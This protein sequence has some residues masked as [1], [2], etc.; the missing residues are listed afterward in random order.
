MQFIDLKFQYSKIK[1]KVDAGIAG[2]L[3][4]GRYIMG[5][6]VVA[7]EE[8]LAGY[9]GTKH[10]LG[11]S[12]GT[13]ALLIALMAIGVKP[14]DEIITTPFTFIA[15]GEVIALAG[16]KP[17]YV[18]IKEDTYNI[19]VTKIEEKITSKTKAI[20]P[21]S[22]YGQCADYD[23]IN[24]IAEKHNLPVIEDGAQSFGGEYKGKKSCGLTTLGCTSFF[25]SKPL[26]A[27]GDGGA[28]FTNDEDL[29]KKMAQIRDHGQAARYEHTIVGLNGRLD[30]MQAAVLLAKMDIFE[31]EV[32][33]RNEVAKRYND[34]FGESV[35]TPTVENHNKSVFA[36]YTVRV[37]NRESVLASLGEAGIPTA[38]HYPKPLHLQ[39][40]FEN[41]GHKEG[42][43]PVSEKVSK[44]VFSIPMHP[45]LKEE[46]QKTV[47]NG[48]KLAIENS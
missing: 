30:S 39:P 31:T 12:S 40:V 6:E 11:V 24:A 21:V 22:L 36:Q 35:I 37:K 43:F 15:T 20:M 41:L 45:Y 8:R 7:L 42:D 17:V 3:E 18:D 10:C 13:D 38:I 33:L 28:V 32:S 16:A 19:D 46:D 44:E 29:H 27:Y 47:V 9:V 2:V 5:P 23:A 14:G 1:D 34:L 4:H 26:G 25:P 48:V